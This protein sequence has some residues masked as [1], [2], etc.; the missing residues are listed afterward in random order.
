MF[1]ESRN[2]QL[3]G[4]DI[5]L[6][7]KRAIFVVQKPIMVVHTTHPDHKGGMIWEGVRLFSLATSYDEDGG[8]KRIGTGFLMDENRLY[9]AWHP[10]GTEEQDPYEIKW[11]QAFW[12]EKQRPNLAENAS[13]KQFLSELPR[14][15]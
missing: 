3:T 2:R 14:P 4:N 8:I 9:F 6:E 12:G 7:L 1:L 15:V 13:F 11:L 10:E 5:A